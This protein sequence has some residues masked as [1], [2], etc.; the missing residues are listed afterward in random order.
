MI[1]DEHFNASY[2]VFHIFSI[3]AI[4]IHSQIA[5]GDK[6][7]NVLRMAVV[8]MHEQR[9]TFKCSSSFIRVFR[10]HSMF[11]TNGRGGIP[12]P[13]GESSGEEI[14]LIKQVA[15]EK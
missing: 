9:S 13:L 8:F 10:L 14:A 5:A 1:L 7:L 2:P 6:N 4:F 11:S 3:M 12:K 15:K